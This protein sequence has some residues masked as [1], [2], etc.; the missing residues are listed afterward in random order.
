MVIKYI[1]TLMETQQCKFE[2]NQ[3][4]IGVVSPY[5]LQCEMIR[6]RCRDEFL[7]QITVGT[8]EI[9]QGQEK[10]IMI[11]STVCVDTVTKFAKNDR[12]RY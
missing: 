12:V 6:T 11:V 9:F 10:P 5:K 8:A 1:Q 2:I 7:N 4:H 3:S